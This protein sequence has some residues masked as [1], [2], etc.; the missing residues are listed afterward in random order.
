M[1]NPAITRRIWLFTA[2][3]AA[4]CDAE[5]IQSPSGSMESLLFSASSVTE[6][7]TPVLLD[8]PINSASRELSAAL[9]PDGLSLY[10]GSDRGGFGAIDIWASRRGCTTCPWGTPVN[11][12]S[13][14]N[15]AGGDGGAVLSP[16]GHVLFFSSARDGTLGGEDLW[17]SFRRDTRNDLAWGPAI[18]LGPKVNT[19]SDE[20]GPAYVRS[21]LLTGTLLYFDRNGDIFQVVVRYDGRVTVAA[22]PV[23]ELNS[24]ATDMGVSISADGK[25]IFFGSLRAGGIGVSDIWTSTRARLGDPWSAPR[26][27]GA[28]VNSQFA[29]LPGHLSHDG[30]TMVFQA[31]AQRGG[32]GLQ[33]I[34]MTTRP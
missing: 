27:L 19:P 3:S 21:L 28:P 1:R 33:D 20:R 32:L 23:A 24:T 14:I 18:N 26:N 16:S 31:G 4:A 30:K 6:W 12:G 7:A 22:E 29:D 5:R 10:F 34:W 11:L 8:A 15:S 25:E 9:S 2:I 17:I 13:N